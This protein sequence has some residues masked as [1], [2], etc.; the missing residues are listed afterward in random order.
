MYVADLGQRFST[1]HVHPSHLEGLLY[2]IFQFSAS[3]SA[4]LTSSQVVL[5]L[6]I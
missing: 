4:F 1:L 6:L 3:E 2:Q 5:L